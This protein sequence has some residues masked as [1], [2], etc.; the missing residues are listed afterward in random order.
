MISSLFDKDLIKSS[1]KNP[2]VSFF[3]GGIGDARHLYRTLIG[4]ASHEKQPKA[5]E[6][7]YHFTLNDINKCALARDLINLTPLDDLSQLGNLSSDEAI[8]IL[9]TVY[10]IFIGTMM[11]QAAF[12]LLHK[13]IDRALEAL[14]TGQQLLSWVYL[15]QL[16]IKFYI[17]AFTLWKG[18][19]LTVFTNAKVIS[20]VERQF[21]RSQ[22][23][24][25]G[26]YVLSGHPSLNSSSSVFRLPVT[27][28]SRI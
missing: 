15:H 26:M 10:F 19:G 22:M 9:T 16:D 3:F 28:F 25:V 8:E 1:T 14:K 5:T 18:P 27:V 17:E 13:T 6:K 2:N 24:G 21:E 7:N 4:I 20:E 23:F 11:P 12:D